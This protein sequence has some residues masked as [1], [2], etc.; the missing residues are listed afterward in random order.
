M[1]KLKKL[2]VTIF[3]AFN[4]HFWEIVRKD[5]IFVGFRNSDFKKF[6]THGILHPFWDFPVNC[7]EVP[8]DLSRPK[9]SV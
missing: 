6:S 1:T 4:F 7:I 5:E 9:H 2:I 8:F 3:F